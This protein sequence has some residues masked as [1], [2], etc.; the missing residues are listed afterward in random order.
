MKRK[1]FV[2]KEQLI[3]DYSEL[4]SMVG[5]A[6]KYGVSKKLIYNYMRKFGIARTNRNHKNIPINILKRMADSGM[7]TKEASNIVGLGYSYIGRIARENGFKFIDKFHPG[8]ITRD[9][10]YIMRYA[11]RH[12]FKNVRNCVMEHRLVVEKHLGRYLTQDEVVHHINRNP[13]DNRIENLT[14]MSKADHVSLH[15]RSRKKHN[16]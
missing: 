15:S 10:G 3:N 8:F 9:R 5:V 1:F 14:V 2:T 7:T 12:P 13:R 11:Y 16:N 4:G 6:L